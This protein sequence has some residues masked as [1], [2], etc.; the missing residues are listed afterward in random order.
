MEQPTS[1]LRLVTPDQAQHWLTECLY[2]RQRERQQWQ[3]NRLAIEMERGRFVAGTQIHFGVLDGHWKLVNG[4][5]TLAAIVQ[6]GLS[7]TLGILQTP[8]RNKVELGQL[9][10]RHDRHR[11]RTPHDVFAGMGLS[12]DLGLLESQTNAFGAA[13]RFVLSDFQ[14]PSIR[15]DIEMA[16]S[17]DYLAAKMAEWA[18]TARLYFD[19]ISPANGVMKPKFNRSPV[20]AIGLATMLDQQERAEAFWRGAAADDGLRKADPRKA[21]ITFL[22]GKSTA[23]GDPAVYMKYVAAL[24]NAFFEGRKVT[25]V[26][27]IDLGKI[28]VTI[29]GTRFKPEDPQRRSVP[30]PLGDIRVEARP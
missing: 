19:A 18:P 16:K 7:I 9:Y 8:V 4:Q 27:P 22:V 26:R 21:L 25:A 2:E 14:R 12:S 3:I 30:A 28:G 24:W 23:I 5:H 6:T 1:E 29:R 10:G 15:R 13:L 11:S 17:L 20:I